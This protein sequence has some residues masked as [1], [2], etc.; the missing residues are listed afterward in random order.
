MHNEGFTF[1]KNYPRRTTHL[2]R[3]SFFIDVIFR[4]H[5]T[6]P[7]SYTFPHS[8]YLF[9]SV[10]S[11]TMDLR[12]SCHCGAVTYS[13]KSHTPSPVCMLMYD[14]HHT[15]AHHPFEKVYALL[16]VTNRLCGHAKWTF[17]NVCNN[18]DVALFVARPAVEEDLLSISW[19]WKTL[20][21]WR[22]KK[23]CGT[24]KR[25]GVY[26]A[27]ETYMQ[28]NDREYRAL[29]DKKTKELWYVCAWYRLLYGLAYTWW[30]YC[31]GNIRYFCGQC[32]KHRWW[33]W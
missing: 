17:T 14:H 31:S 6:F 10:R 22:V 26:Y 12:G 4:L 15:C 5:K 23:T 28:Y 19:A 16:L 2:Q 25:L 21:L 32:G 1:H 20:W 9:F 13:F 3:R 7:P 24:L 8:L 33:Q 29:R 18:L 27:I 11:T 30:A